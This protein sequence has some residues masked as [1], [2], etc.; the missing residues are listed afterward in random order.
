MVGT[1]DREA[2]DSDDE[3]SLGWTRTGAFG[4]LAKIWE[5]NL[6]DSGSD[7]EANPTDYGDAAC[8]SSD[9]DIPQE[10]TRWHGHP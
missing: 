6:A 9:P 3:R 10:G 5:G 2:D 7:L 4:L 8:W 1:G